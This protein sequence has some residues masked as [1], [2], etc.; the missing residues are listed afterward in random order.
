MKLAIVA[1]IVVAICLLASYVMSDDDRDGPEQ[2]TVA[3]LGDYVE[4]GL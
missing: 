1:T 3:E 4:F 2:R